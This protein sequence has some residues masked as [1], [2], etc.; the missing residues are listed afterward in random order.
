MS[1][2]TVEPKPQKLSRREFLKFSTGAAAS[3]AVVAA[4]GP[5]NPVEAKAE[6]AEIA[7]ERIGL[8]EGM[9]SPTKLIDQL[10]DK[11]S[12][13]GLEDGKYW[14]PFLDMFSEIH[15]SDPD[16]A[17]KNRNALDYAFG[18]RGLGKRIID[19]VTEELS[20]DTPGA[21]LDKLVSMGRVRAGDNQTL[22]SVVFLFSS[23]V[24]HSSADLSS[25]DGERLLSGMKDV[26]QWVEPMAEHRDY[27]SEKAVY[28]DRARKLNNANELSRNTIDAWSNGLEESQGVMLQILSAQDEYFPSASAG[29][30]SINP[31][32]SSYHD[33]NVL[34]EEIYVYS[35][36]LDNWVNYEDPNGLEYF[37]VSLLH[38][39]MHQF[40]RDTMDFD[41]LQ[42]LHPEDVLEDQELR[43]AILKELREKVAR[44]TPSDINAF[45]DDPGIAI[46]FAS[47]QN[48][49][50]ERNMR[51]MISELQ[52]AG[53]VL[54]SIDM[55][56]TEVRRVGMEEFFASEGTANPGQGRFRYGNNQDNI[57]RLRNLSLPLSDEQQVMQ[58]Y[59]RLMFATYALLVKLDKAGLLREKSE[60][61][62]VYPEIRKIVE[63][64]V[65]HAT[66]GP[67]GEY[68]HP[69]T[70]GINLRDNPFLAMEKLKE[71]AAE[72]RKGCPATEGS[73]DLVN[74]LYDQT[75]LRMEVMARVMGGN[76]VL[77]YTRFFNEIL[78]LPKG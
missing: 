57:Q 60:L 47:V 43:N 68:L 40:Q 5:G 69:R 27:E 37:V 38:E 73:V 7:K 17:R 39:Q 31:G 65:M 36:A 22:N 4:F 6:Q 70:S 16:E 51:A 29:L 49:S 34:V 59:S 71:E 53:R 20:V 24:T 42:V 25:D 28:A 15:S 58:E 13:R 78:Q 64:Q 18:E 32:D 14:R 55:G 21:S 2:D 19:A 74:F 30:G 45:V 67:P 3:G 46:K 10:V 61:N 35:E 63:G 11:I 48:L 50:Q 44:M 56:D 33:S 72:A 41:L 66:M 9:K 26:L 23:A 54:Q 52:L 12:E 75:P 8:E 62:R 77:D 1:E 76:G